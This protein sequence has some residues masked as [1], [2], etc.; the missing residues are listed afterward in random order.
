MSKL[1]VINAFLS[2]CG[3]NSILE[4]IVHGV[5]MIVWPL[6]VE[7]RMNAVLL[8]DVLKVAVKPE[9]VDNDEDRI[10]KREEITRVIKRMMEENEEGLEM[11]KRIKQ[12]SDA[13]TTA[14]T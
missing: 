14:L 12:L 9:K 2:H 11:R 8:K 4:S 13:A 7:Q 1:N 6:F 5:P 3:W 10:V